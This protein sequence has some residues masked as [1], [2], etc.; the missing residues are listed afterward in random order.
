M[1]FLITA[2]AAVLVFGS[3][4][5]IHEFG[6]FITAKR[7]G[8]TELI[9]S[10]ENRKDVEEIKPEYLE[11]LKFNFVATNDEVLNLALK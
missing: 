8:I 10:D 9:L 5:F 3:V 6:H 1:S 2:A 7:A 4:V 11:G